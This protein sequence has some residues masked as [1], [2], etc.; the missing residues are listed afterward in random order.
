M[1]GADGVKNSSRLDAAYNDTVGLTAAFNLNLLARVQRELGAD[2]DRGAFEHL[3]FFNPDQ[4]RIEMHLL[5]AQGAQITIEDQVFYL[6]P[7]ET[8]HTENSWK[9][10]PKRLESLAISAH[11][12][13]EHVWRSESHTFYLALMQVS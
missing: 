3:S 9:F 5:A 2:L 8:I 11:L 7:G 1:I 6:E 10:N 4:E 13:L 12:N